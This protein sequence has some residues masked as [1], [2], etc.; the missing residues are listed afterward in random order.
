MANKRIKDLPVVIATTTGDVVAIDGATT[1]GVTVENF[2]GDNLAALKS[3]T[4]AADKLAYFNGAGTADI[5]DLTAQ[6]RALLGDADATAQRATIGLD[7]VDNTSDAT[8]NA[9]AATLTNKTIDT[10]GP[11]V[12]KI[13]GNTLDASAGAAT[14]TLPN[15]T[16]TLVGRD[17][18]DTLT[19]KTL[20]SPVINSPSGLVSGDVGLGDVDNTSD[21]DKP[22]STATQSAL[23][24]KADKAITVSAGTGLTGGGDLSSNR[25]IALDSASVASLG[26]ADTAVQPARVVN[27]G[28][29]LTGGGDLSADRTIALDTAS[30]ASLALADT[31]VQR[32]ELATVA[33]SGAY[34]D[35]SNTPVPIPTGGSTGQALVKK[36]NA[37]YDYEW[38]A[39]GGGG[40]GD[41]LKSAYDQSGLSIDVFGGRVNVETVA[42]ADSLVVGAAPSRVVTGAF[43]TDRDPGSSVEFVDAGTSDPSSPGQIDITANSV[44]HFYIRSNKILRPQQFGCKTGGD[45]TA[46]RAALVEMFALADAEGREIDM[47]SRFDV[48]EIDDEISVAWTRKPVIRGMGATIK[49][50][51]SVLDGA[52][53]RAVYFQVDNLGFDL[54]GFSVDA[55]FNANYALDIRNQIDT[56]VEADVY[57]GRLV[58][59]SATGGVQSVSTEPGA[60]GV[61]ITGWFRNLLLDEVRVDEIKRLT[62]AYDANYAAMAVY[63][64]RKSNGSSHPLYKEIRNVYIGKVWDEDNTQTQNMDGLAIFDRYPS[65]A[66]DIPKGSTYITGGLIKDCWGRGGKFQASNISVVGL[67]G[68]LNSAPSGDKTICFL[69]FQFGG[70]TVVGGGYRCAGASPTAIIDTQTNSSVNHPTVISGFSAQQDWSGGTPAINSFAWQYTNNLGAGLYGGV[71]VRDCDLNVALREII[72]YYDSNSSALTSIAVATGNRARLSQTDSCAIRFVF[73]GSQV[74]AGVIKDNI[75]SSTNQKPLYRRM[76]TSGTPITGNTATVLGAA[77]DN[78]YFSAG[79]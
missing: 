73:R 20:T 42:D 31:A 64:G 38:G 49:L 17:T 25:S 58:G 36:S 24:L 7:K 78:F 46:N 22:I 37:D 45:P 2:L 53:S 43:D 76:N 51:S 63:I 59:V 30:Q 14:V 71:T 47:G 75:N 35:L 23:N 18:V 34:D 26:K 1:R 70:G 55:G 61:N 72:Q 13:N 41:M 21:L 66:D 4:T 5:T 11:N 56:Y 33:I 79:V 40:S 60:R 19:N 27:T 74:L 3:L 57:D 16:D 44:T 39:G 50:T 10:A 52:L 54:E 65:G 8:K 6:A 15:T 48:Y 77:A 67:Y 28:T 62:G 32:S 68:E 9:A 12:I 29:G 69:D